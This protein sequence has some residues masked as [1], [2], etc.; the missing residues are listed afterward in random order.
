MMSLTRSLRGRIAIATF[1]LVALVLT[2]AGLVLHRA[3]ERFVDQTFLDRLESVALGLLAVI[4][5]DDN[6][7]I[8]LLRDIGDAAF[9]RVRSG[10]YWQISIN[11]EPIATS[12]SLW[13]DALDEPMSEPQTIHDFPGPADQRL[14]AYVHRGFAPGLDDPL[15]IIVTAPETE[16]DR[17]LASIVRPLLVALGLLAIVLTLSAVAVVHYTTRPLGATRRALEQLRRGETTRVIGPIPLELEPLIDDLH[18]LLDHSAALVKRSREHLADLAHALKTPLAVVR[19][20][21]DA[22]P[23]DQRDGIE[24]ALE[25]VERLI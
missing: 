7:D 13:L 5:L 14:L 22:L 20:Q 18:S 23:A 17:H 1:C 21:L 8:V 24:P 11:S 10:W 25:Q 19:Q 9:E 16:I 4:E 3:L 2:S 12:R 15:T 6:D